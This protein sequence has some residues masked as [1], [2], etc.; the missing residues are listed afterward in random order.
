MVGKERKLSLA[1]KEEDEQPDGRLQLTNSDCA[2]LKIVLETG[3]SELS[4][5]HHNCR[6][7]T[8]GFVSN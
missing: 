4:Q 2:L 7:S 3:G 1:K 8:Q 5:C 6:D